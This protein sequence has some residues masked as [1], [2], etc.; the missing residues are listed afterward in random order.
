MPNDTTQNPKLT[1]DSMR[2]V[3]TI[4]TTIIDV[5][6]GEEYWVCQCYTWL[7]QPPPRS[8]HN[9]DNQA[10]LTTKVIFIKIMQDHPDS[11]MR[12]KS[13]DLPLKPETLQQKS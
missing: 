2:A 6:R 10:I 11:D 5:G 9:N 7:G 4:M 12:L 13:S 3:T 1:N 8:T